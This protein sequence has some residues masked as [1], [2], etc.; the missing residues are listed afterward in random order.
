MAQSPSTNSHRTE[1]VTCL[2]VVCGCGVGRWSGASDGGG[3][4]GGGGGGAAPYTTSHTV[5]G[6]LV[7]GVCGADIAGWPPPYVVGSGLE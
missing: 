5:C 4:G 1:R 3:G 7:G 6:M 2:A